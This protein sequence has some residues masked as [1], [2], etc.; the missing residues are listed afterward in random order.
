VK[1]FLSYSSK[2]RELVEPVA[3]ALNAEAHDVFFDREDLPAGDEYDARIRKAIEAS[4]LF[5]FFISP[6]SL[7]AGSYTLTELGIASRKW[8]HPKGRVLPVVLKGMPF[9][10]IP[11]YL[12]AVTLLEPKGNVAADVADTVARISRDRRRTTFITSAGIAAVLAVG[13]AGFLFHFYLSPGI[14]GKD[15][16]V[17]LPVAGGPFVMGD[18]E[19]WVRREVFLR[20]FYIDQYEVTVS[21]FANFDGGWA[22]KQGWDE[23]ELKKYADYPVTNVSWHEAN[24][25]CR[26]AGKR[27]PTS[28]EWE[29]AARGTDERI[30]PWGNTAPTTDVATFEK[31]YEKDAYGN[32]VSA[33]SSHESGRSPFGIHNLAGNV[34]EW[35]ADWYEEGKSKL[36]RGGGWYD[37][38]EKIRSAKRWHASPDHTSDDLGFRCALDASS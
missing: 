33:V 4:H 17:A 27:L 34:S 2:D 6:N 1:I 29:K 15:G 20:P 22:K 8:E 14:S 25:Y 37:G 3:L 31:D 32:G 16:A 30:F 7:R 11:A 26:W 9:E 12:K 24:A 38:A 13:I 18:D 19:E 36:I 10:Q 28:A 35:V 5:V 21:R 23:N